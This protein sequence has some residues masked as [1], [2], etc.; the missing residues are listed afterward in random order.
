MFKT[1]VIELP[2]FIRLTITHYDTKQ[3]TQKFD[4]ENPINSA[5][6]RIKVINL[7]LLLGYI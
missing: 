3:S 5:F 4:I 6:N 7:S 1:V 2:D